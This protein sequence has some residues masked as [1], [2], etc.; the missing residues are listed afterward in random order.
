MARQ[1]L[2]LLRVRLG[3]RVEG[4]QLEHVVA[5]AGD[6]APVAGGAGLGRAADDAAGDGGGGPGD[7]VDAEAVGGKGGV[8]DGVVL[9]LEDA[10]VAVGRGAGEEAA[11]LVRGPGHDVDRGLVQGVV[12]DAL[13]LRALLGALLLPD[14][15]LAVEARR[16]EDVAV[17]GVRPGDAPNRSLVTVCL[18]LAITVAFTSLEGGEE[19]RNGTLTP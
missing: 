17:L 19:N 7:R 12:V 8:V 3:G 16:G 11:G 13:P 9:E 2:T 6:E 10:D 15:D 5:A 4:P 14:E 1:G 18:V